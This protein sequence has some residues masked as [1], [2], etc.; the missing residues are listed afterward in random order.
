MKKVLQPRGFRVYRLLSQAEEYNLS[1]MHLRVCLQ[2]QIDVYT[3]TGISCA[4][5]LLE[6]PFL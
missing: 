5:F 1:C 6:E 4:I 2:V 3:F